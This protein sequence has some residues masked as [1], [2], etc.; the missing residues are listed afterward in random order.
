MDTIDYINAAKLFTDK[1]STMPVLGMIAVN[2]KIQ[3][4]DLEIS[5]QA[6]HAVK[7]QGCFEPAVITSI[8]LGATEFKGKKTAGYVDLEEYPT[9]P[10]DAVYGLPASVPADVLIKQFTAALVCAS[11]D[12]TRYNIVCVCLDLKDISVPKLVSTDGHRL[13][14]GELGWCPSTK[15][16]Q[17]LLPAGGI[18]KLVT[19]LR[20]RKGQTVRVSLGS[21]QGQKDCTAYA[22]FQIGEVETVYMRLVDGQFPDWRQVVPRETKTVL[23]I[24]REPLLDSLKLVSAVATDKNKAVRLK[25]LEN[26]LELSSESPELGK[27]FQAVEEPYAHTIGEPVEIG[28]AGK[29]LRAYLESVK[30]SDGITVRFDGDLGPVIFETTDDVSFVVIMPIRF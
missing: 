24:E 23:H 21:P 18:K 27:A 30:A 13:Y 16:T 12:C 26:K 19:L 11:T 8:I 29:Y 14:C 10:T 5:Y 9:L 2:G 15:E 17:V 3:A 7:A 4:T 28:L 20:K 6:D 1:R 25:V 22:R